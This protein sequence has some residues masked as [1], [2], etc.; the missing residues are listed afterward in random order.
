MTQAAVAPL[1]SKPRSLNTTR[2]VHPPALRANTLSMMHELHLLLMT[3][4][5]RICKKHDIPFFLIGGTLLGAVRHKGFIPWD[6]DADIGMFREDH[7]R[8]L[9]ACKTE[10]DHNKFFLQTLHTDK[11]YGLPF[12]K[13]QLK[14]TKFVERNAAGTTASKGIF[15]DIFPFDNVPEDKALREKQ[16]RRT[17]VLKRLLLAKLGY[18]TWNSSQPLKRLI[19]KLMTL[20][21]KL[22]SRENMIAKLE[23]EMKRHNGTRTE[24]VVVIGGSYGYQK[25][26]I[27]RD[28]FNQTIDMDFEGEA[29]PVPAAYVPYLEHLYGDYMTPP[30]VSKRGNRHDILQIDFGGWRH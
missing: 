13:L 16:D 29:F 21:T 11:G 7:D 26:T 20:Y 12:A 10:L 4:V 3:E 30:P 1:L 22:R 28:W 2:E 5:R 14:N 6:D 18:Q 24:H 25:E 17:Y 9:A 19:Y 23:K 15:V 27:R 8:F